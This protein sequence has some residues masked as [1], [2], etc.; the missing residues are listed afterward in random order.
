MSW[1]IAKEIFSSDMVKKI[2][3]AF[4]IQ[5]LVIT[6][7]AFQIVLAIY[8]RRR[9]Y[10]PRLYVLF[11]VWFCYLMGTY[12]SIVALGKLTETSSND[13]IALTNIT[14]GSPPKLVHV[15]NNE[16]R[17]LWAPLLL[18]HIGGPDSITAYAV[19]DNRLGWRQFL[20][21]GVQI[22]VVLLIYIKS[23]NNSWLSI[24][25]LTLLVSGAIKSLERV[26]S[27]R[28]S[29]NTEAIF[30]SLSNSS[31]LEVERAWYLKSSIPG[32]EL[33]V[34]A[35]RRFEHLKPHL[36]NWIGHPLSIN[37]PSMST[38]Y[39]DPEDVFKIAEFELGFMYDV[40]YTRSPINYSFPSFLRRFVCLL[41]LVSSLCGFA[42]LFRNADVHLL[43]IV[44]TVKYDKRVDIA[45]TYM[46][47]AG[48]I[49]LEL[50]A[51]ATILYS[52]WSLLY[53][54][55]DQKSPF[56]EN[57]LQVFARQVPMRWPRWSNSIQQLNLL[58]YCLYK[59]HTLS[60]RIISRTLMIRPGWDEAYKRYCLTNYVPVLGDLKRLLIEQIEEVC[61]QRVWQPFSKR[62]EWA[63]ERFKCVDQFKWSIQT[64]YT[65]EANQ[66]TSFGRAIII[67]H[68]A[69]DVWFYA[70]DKYKT[71]YQQSYSQMTKYLSDYMVH[72]LADR[73]YMLNIVTKNILFEGA[74]AKLAIFLNTI[75]TTRSESV[76]ECF[77]RN[78]L[79]SRLEET[80]LEIGCENNVADNFH[81]SEAIV[82]DWDIVMEAKLLAELLIDRADRWNLLA[83]VWIEMLCYAASNCPWVRHT[84]QLR[85]GGGLITHV[86]LL[87]YHETNKFNISIY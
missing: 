85:R 25:A 32:L 74:C 67:W 17:A 23:W 15:T 63:L 26:W 33:L 54:I 36:Q 13:S 34:K 28:C 69:T 14:Y 12:V 84:E 57:L 77:S 47:L 27:L 49:A 7:L 21:L 76:M 65:T 66:Q 75:E 31:I 86:W 39:Y 81:S 5:A 9:K 68:I 51:L 87:L 79:E 41:C 4:E 22:G 2:W 62:G 80:S 37:F 8:G 45:I 48:A 82:S 56:V 11:V 61:G 18:V 78:L 24:I 43:T 1:G 29:A 50:Y 30:N 55:K 64:D 16:L 46:L 72:L 73:P 83:S 35:Y 20:E 3:D 70:P 60:G 52:D 71:H 53:M 59:D 42:I 44:S 38:Y 58:S 6:S 10:N 19:E 40:L